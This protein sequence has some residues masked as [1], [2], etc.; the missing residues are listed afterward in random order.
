MA[1]IY[2]C[3]RYGVCIGRVEN[4]GKVYENDPR[5]CG[6]KGS[7][8]AK[9]ADY[10]PMLKSFSTTD[11]IPFDYGY[12]EKDDYFYMLNFHLTDY[13]RENLLP[14]A[15]DEITF[16]FLNDFQYVVISDIPMD[17]FNSELKYVISDIYKVTNPQQIK[18]CFV[19]EEIYIQ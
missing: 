5:V 7:D 13:T 11:S 1:K 14:D 3:E 8:V 15:P 2:N 4:D 9:M 18:D 19:A 16:M 10:L 12:F 6:S 17:T